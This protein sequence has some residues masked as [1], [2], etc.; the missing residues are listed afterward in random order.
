MAFDSSFGAIYGGLSRVALGAV[1][2]V[3]DISNG[4]FAGNTC[5]RLVLVFVDR[6]CRVQTWVRER[7]ARRRRRWRGVR[8][9]SVNEAQ[10]EKHRSA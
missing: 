7:V 4:L 2:T 10:A 6:S 1:K 3:F 9:G 8:C 5:V